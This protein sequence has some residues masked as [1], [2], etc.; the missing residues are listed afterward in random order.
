MK[1]FFKGVRK[2]I[3]RLDAE[4]LREQYEIVSDEFSRIEMLLSALHEGI[5]RVGAGGAV[6]HANPAALQILGSDPEQT[7]AAMN[8]PLG[9]SSKREMTLTYPENRHLEVKTIPFERETIVYLRDVTAEKARTE[10]ELRAGAT[11]AVCELAAGVAHEIGNPLNA[12]S[13][14]LQLLERDPNDAEAL[15]TCREQVARLDGII[16]GF[17]SALRPVKPNLRPGTPAEPL[18]ACLSAMRQQLVERKINVTLESPS[19]LPPV[20]IDLEQMQ[21][22]FFNLMKNSLEAMTD[23]GSVNISLQAD[24]S[25]VSISFTDSGMGMSEDQLANLFESYRTSKEGGN[26]LG[27]MVSARIVRDHGGTIAAESKIGEGTTFTIRLPRLEKRVRV[28]K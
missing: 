19:A 15:K 26:G 24:D 10:D 14:N 1:N 23:G 13:L 2:H 8:L 11:K 27:L 7:L 18:K 20:A 17:L 28:L 9:R 16:R 3:K 5:V 22:V 6:L 4:H 12:I 21:Q 25:D